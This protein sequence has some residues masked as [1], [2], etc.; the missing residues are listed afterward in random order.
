MHFL[1]TTLSVLA[2]LAL[3][4][5]PCFA[6]SKMTKDVKAPASAQAVHSV[7][8]KKTAHSVK[9]FRRDFSKTLDEFHKSIGMF[10]FV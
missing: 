2:V 3:A 5:Q 6:A 4:L 7:A 9:K 8:T 10:F 1:T